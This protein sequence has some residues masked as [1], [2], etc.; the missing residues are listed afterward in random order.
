[1]LEQWVNDHEARHDRDADALLLAVRNEIALSAASTNPLNAAL[2]WV[3][4]LIALVLVAVLGW[5]LKK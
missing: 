1:M 4:G 3:A 2:K 5:V